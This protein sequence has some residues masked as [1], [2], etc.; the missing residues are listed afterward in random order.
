MSLHVH[1]NFVTGLGVAANNR[2]DGEGQHITPLQ[3]IVWLGENYSTVSGE[4]IRFA[5]RR[6]LD[7]TERTG[8]HRFW[9]DALRRNE[10][11]SGSQLKDVNVEFNRWAD[12]NYVG[13]I[14]DDIL[15]FMGTEGAKEET[16]ETEVSSK[17]KKVPGSAVVRRSPLEVTHAV[18]LTPWTGDVTFNVASPMAT[19]GAA[20]NKTH[21]PVPYGTEKHATRY[22]YG[23]GLTPGILRDKS[24]AGKAIIG[25]CTIGPVAGNH[26]RFLFDFSPY[27][28]VFRL[29]DEPASKITFCFETPD[30][31]K[32][33]QANAVLDRID[34]GTIKPDELFLGVD[35]LNSHIAKQF[36]N[37]GVRVGGVMSAANEIIK[38]INRR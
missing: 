29:C 25:L 14:D 23:M 4:A 15:G 7:T 28:V 5:L 6:Y 9:N 16:E 13:Y 21:N 10:W 1:A 11:R 22:Q 20:K 26:G 32:T 3:K 12:Q 2:G 36:R 38:Q 18:S 35:N 17:K 33:V 37:K 34:A 27:A 19:P 8:T 24:R 31:G 30:D